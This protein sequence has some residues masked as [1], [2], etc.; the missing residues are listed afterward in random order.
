MSNTKTLK[1]L[2]SGKTEYLTDKVRPE[3][4][5]TFKTNESI[6]NPTEGGFTIV[7]FVQERDEFTSLC[8]KTGQPD[9]AKLEIIYIPNDLMVES[10]ALKLYLFSFRNT[11]EFHEDVCNRIA[12]DLFDL[13]KPMYLR[14][15]GDFAPRG[16]LAIKPLVTRWSQSVTQSMANE[17]YQQVNAW[18]TKK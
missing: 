13:L 15:Y 8:P 3:L 10:K 9:H 17:I 6:R 14:V 5:E 7:P 11:G 18:D 1:K 2:G 4:L 16:G 12:N